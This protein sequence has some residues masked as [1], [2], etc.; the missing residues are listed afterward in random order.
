M[1][2]KSQ[3]QAAPGSTVPAPV[4]AVRGGESVKRVDAVATEEPLEIRVVVE[5]EGRRERH[6]IAVTM[7]T[8]G[9]DFELA[10]GF[11]CGEGLLSHP[12]EV[13]RIDHCDAGSSA[14]PSNIVEVHLA[15]GVEFEAEQL[16]RHVFTSSSCGVCGRA[17]VEAVEIACPRAPVGTFR[18]RAEDLVN[19]PGYL[20]DAQPAFSKTGGLHAAG[21]FDG[22]A[23]LLVSREDV[24]RHNAVDKVVGGLLLDDQ[25]PASD[26]VLLV[27]G[28]ASFELVQ[29][30]AL[31]GIPVL[32]AVGAPSSLA[33]E[34]ARDMG[35]TL[36]GFLRDGRFNV[37]SGAERIVTD[38]RT[39]SQ[40]SSGSG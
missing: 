30:S 38:G 34:L 1:R 31:A 3:Q 21:L 10:A 37:Y 14:D 26:R 39:G 40:R 23:R 16:T 22:S 33:V 6:S 17:S 35:M 8:P 12:G 19:L 27:S 9:H 32:A 18:L 7:R 29:K 20:R 2:D 28:R 24:G 36:I 13:W 25:L 5:A 11:L 15:P 4:L